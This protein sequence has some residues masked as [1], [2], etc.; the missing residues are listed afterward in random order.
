MNPL[1]AFVAFCLAF[2]ANLRADDTAKLAAL[3]APVAEHGGTVTIPPGDSA[4]D[5]KESIPLASHTTIFAY[6]AQFHLPESLGDKARVVVF[7]GENVSDLRWFGGHFI[8]HV[9]DPAQEGNT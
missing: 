9:F 5:G 6:G 7:S 4:L 2:T 1:L 8:G 3:F